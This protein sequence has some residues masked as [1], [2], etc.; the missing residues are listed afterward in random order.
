MY[1]DHRKYTGVMKHTL[2]TADCESI[3]ATAWNEIIIDVA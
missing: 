3:L 2:Q 1:P